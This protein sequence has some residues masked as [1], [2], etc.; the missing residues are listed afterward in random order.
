VAFDEGL[1][2]RLRVLMD[3]EPL[4]RE[5]RMFGGLAFMV[6]GNMA[7]GIVG[8][9][10]MVRLGPSA[11][12]DAL[13]RPAAREMDFTGRSMRGLVFVAPEGIAEDDDLGR[14]VARGVAFAR[15]L[16]AKGT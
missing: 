7:V 8:D 16:P 13:A 14:W 2:E 15:S 10:L 5:R 11:Y 3:D 6:A 12:D 4:V 1:A 9:D